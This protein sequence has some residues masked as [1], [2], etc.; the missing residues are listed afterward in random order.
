MGWEIDIT[1]DDIAFAEGLMGMDFSDRERRG[2]L[3]CMESC[4]VQACPGGGKTT[5]LVA[6]LAI[7]SR[8]I[9]DERLGICVLSHTNAARIEI[10]RSLGAHAG[11]LFRYPHFVGTI[12][13]FV[14]RFL[15]I[16]AL[17]TRFGI[18]PTVID[19][20]AFESI[21]AAAWT[22]LAPGVRYFLNKKS[23]DNGLGLLKSVRYRFSDQKLCVYDD[24]HERDLAGEETA[25][26]SAVGKLKNRVTTEGCIAYHDAYAMANWYLQEYP[27]LARLFCLRFPYVFID[28]MQD[29]D[30]FQWDI[31][32]T[33]FSRSPVVQ[34]LGD[35]NQA[36]FGRSSSSAESGWRP[37]N[38]LHVSNSYRLSNSIAKLCHNV[39]ISPQALVGNAHRRE[40]R[41]T[42][43]LFDDNTIKG[44]VHAFAELVLAEG[45]TRGPFK[46]VGAVGRKHERDARK[47]SISSYWPAFR[48]RR[49]RLA[50]QE[51]LR[52]YFE[53]AGHELSSGAACGLACD[54][55]LLGLAQVLRSQRT[56]SSDGRPFTAS[57]LRAAL[58]ARGMGEYS[59]FRN[60][61]T[62]WC[63][64]LACEG[65]CSWVEVVDATHRVLSPLIEGPFSDEALAF[66][67]HSGEP[68]VCRDDWRPPVNAC[69]HEGRG[70]SVI[71]EIDTIHG[72]KGQTHQATLLLETF[73]Y[74]YDL[75]S[76]L[77]YL[78][79]ESVEKHGKR[80]RKRL[81]LAYVAMTRPTELLCLAMH[82][83]HLGPADRKALVGMGWEIQL[84]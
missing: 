61:L 67:H 7:L 22:N 13:K 20:D 78:K 4:D 84:V 30:N 16:P 70:G 1:D 29:T 71:I 79:G 15:A 57:S 41:H 3:Q 24:G 25:S 11:R 56:T 82:R 72:I 51:G 69:E 68:A 36:I 34:R 77:R 18:R 81:P 19:D 5:M 9:P 66:L 35:S 74:D 83:E 65:R 73:L 46:A 27:E 31:L 32:S 54:W 2:V 55:I 62:A 80:N 14:D 50:Q 23:G 76:L 28:E 39:S 48:K 42:I 38:V 12:Q 21:V 53:L 17:I 63:K 44:V 49:A 26:H 58:K 33:V 40:R 60:Q 52:A 43:L 64:E 59:A 47:Y 37:S 8:K 10:E 75:K 45:L 6:K